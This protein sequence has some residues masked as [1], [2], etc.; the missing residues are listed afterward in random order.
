MQDLFDSFTESLSNGLALDCVDATSSLSH[1][2]L[3]PTPQ[4]VVTPPC[5]LRMPRGG[6]IP[7]PRDAELGENGPAP[8]SPGLHLAS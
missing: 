7:L 2:A 8:R 4:P 3:A 6:R 5:A 1:E